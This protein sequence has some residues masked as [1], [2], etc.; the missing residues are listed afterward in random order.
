MKNKKAAA[1]LMACALAAASLAGCGSKDTPADNSGASK[2]TED[3]EEEDA[4]KETAQ[5]GTS[6]MDAIKIGLVAPISGDNGIYGTSQMQGY[7]LAMKEINEVGGVNG[8]MLELET[9]DDQGDAQKAAA[10]AQKFADDDSILAIGGSCLSSCTLAMVPIIDDAGLPD[11]VISSSSPNLTGVSDY[12][13]RMSVQDEAVGPQIADVILNKGLKDVV[14]LYPD[15]DYGINLNENLVNYGKEKGLNILESITYLTTD[16]DYTAMLTTVKNLKPEAVALCGTTTDSGLL[17]KQ[18]KQL[19]IEALL[20]GGTGPY[21]SKTVEIAGSA[22]EGMLCVGV[23][24]ATNP[25]EKV[26]TLVEKYENAYGEKPDGFAALAYDQMY[27]IAEAAKAAM[28]ANGGEVTRDTLKDALKEINYEAVTG[29][30]TFNENNDWERPYLTLR[31]E[32][33]EFV[34]DEE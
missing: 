24:V 13:F 15:N 27:V 11:L 22:S 10:G 34:M 5:G 12:F 30:V 19:G 6:T 3:A 29:N 28:D 17:V 16:Q 8:A 20:V 25:N 1:L 7:E 31:V 4:E 2:E 18:M 32:N 23:Y 9:Y 33:S 26:Q 21:N 14:V